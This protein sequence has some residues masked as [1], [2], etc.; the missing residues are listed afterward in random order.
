MKFTT[1]EFEIHGN[2]K[3]PGEHS[4][5]L[6]RLNRPEALN[7][8]TP[9]MVLELDALFDEVRRNSQLKVVIL[10]GNGHGFCSGGDMRQEGSTLGVTD[11]DSGLRGPYRELA[12]YFFT[13]LFH[14]TMQS[15]A[16]KFENLPQVTIAAV[17]GWA[18]G[19]G[20]ELIA[21]ADIRLASDQAKFS[22]AA[23]TAGFVTEIGGARNLP[24]LIGKGRALEMILTGR[25]VEAE[26]AERI[27]LVDRVMPHE[28]LMDAA[29]ELAST[30]AIQPYLSV[31][32]AKQLVNYYWTQ[33]A[34]DKGWTREF[35]AVREIYHTNDNQ[36]GI[37]AF[38]EKRKPVYRGP[39]YPE[40]FPNKKTKTHFTVPVPGEEG[41]EKR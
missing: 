31:L 29:F 18:V 7:A 1:I 34:S 30:I 14:K 10:T 39:N 21:L 9:R 3:R 6:V 25:V 5:A 4:I 2:A 27:G 24:K 13:D 20:L 37:R 26:E 11:I 33:G 17:N 40:Y 32:H 8:I 16:R 22:E 41:K 36:E 12:E 15:C 35:E 19:A 38:L 28:Q 23:V